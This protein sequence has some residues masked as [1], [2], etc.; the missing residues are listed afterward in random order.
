M[1]YRSNIRCLIYAYQRDAEDTAS[2]ADNYEALKTIMNTTFKDV[3]V[4]WEECFT[5]R[6]KCQVVDFKCEDVK[7]YE[8]YPDVAVFTQMLPLIEELEYCYEFVRVGEESDDIEHEAS[9]DHY[10]HLS[11]YTNISCD[12]D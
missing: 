10:G 9:A 6:D 8:S 7:W 3:L 12:L 1:G 5:F 11:T 2:R 4:R